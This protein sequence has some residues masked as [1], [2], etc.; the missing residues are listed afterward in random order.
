M[1][2]AAM[3]LAAVLVGAAGFL[4]WSGLV[5]GSRAF[6]DYRDSPSRAYLT[7]GALYLF[8]ACICVAGALLIVA[9]A[10]RRA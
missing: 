4:A 8:F 3:L 1:R 2:Y 7:A 6:E 9:R 10:R 5:V